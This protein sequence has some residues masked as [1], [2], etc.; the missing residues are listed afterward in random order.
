[1]HN[2]DQQTG[3]MDMTKT[4]L[5]KDEEPDNNDMSLFV[6]PDDNAS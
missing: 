3:N 1:M 4:R 2:E 6:D 5:M